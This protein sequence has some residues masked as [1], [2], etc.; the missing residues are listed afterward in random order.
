MQ[1]INF[2][3]NLFFEIL[4]IIANLLCREL[5]KFLTTLILSVCS[6]LSCLPACKKSTSSLN[7][8]LKYYKEIANLLSWVIWAGLDTHT[9]NNNSNLIIIVIII[10][11]IIIINNNNKIIN[12]NLKKPLTWICRQKT[13]FILHTFLEMLQRYCK[14]IVLDTL[15]MPG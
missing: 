1:K 7:S 2:S 3:F 10:I 14:L 5:W 15:G 8:F 12:S 9:W 4:I 13:K 6:K 11:I